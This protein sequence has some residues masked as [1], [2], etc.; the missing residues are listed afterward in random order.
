[1]RGVIASLALPLVAGL[2]AASPAFAQTRTAD[3]C[4]TFAADRAGGGP[5]RSYDVG[6]EGVYMASY[7]D[8]MR[9]HQIMLP[10]RL[11]PPLETVE[12]VPG[13]DVEAARI[14][15]EEDVWA[16]EDR[17]AY[18]V[19]KYRSYNPRTGMFLSYSGEWRPCR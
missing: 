16:G 5:G 7:R 17:H 3:F 4:N 11:L 18:C 13:A 9:A 15:W 10:V 1:M 14:W 12:I 19:A 2:L 6:A 8:C